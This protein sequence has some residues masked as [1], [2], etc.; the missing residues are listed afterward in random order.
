MSDLGSSFLKRVWKNLVI[1]SRKVHGFSLHILPPP[2]RLLSGLSLLSKHAQPNYLSADIFAGPRVSTRE[3]LMT[4]LPARTELILRRELLIIILWLQ[5]G[6]SGNSQAGFWREREV[7]ASSVGSNLHQA[8]FSALGGLGGNY[9]P[10][11]P[12]ISLLWVCGVGWAGRGHSCSCLTAY[13]PYP[14]QL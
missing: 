7:P 4:T 8:Q 9:V 2:T 11:A 10:V 6:L 5:P 13:S 14:G 3:L 12:Q 1:F